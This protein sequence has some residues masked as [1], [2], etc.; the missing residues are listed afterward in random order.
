V[1]GNV[2]PQLDT[3]GAIIAGAVAGAVLSTVMVALS[4]LKPRKKK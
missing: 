4:F 3:R 2:N 1:E